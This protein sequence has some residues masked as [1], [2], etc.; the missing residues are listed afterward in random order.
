M[1][2]IRSLIRWKHNNG[3]AVS[4]ITYCSEFEAMNYFS[5]VGCLSKIVFN[6]LIE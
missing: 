1:K 2:F 6:G 4:L 3:L 5:G